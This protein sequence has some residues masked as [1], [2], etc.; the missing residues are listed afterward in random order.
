[1]ATESKKEML[2]VGDLVTP[3]GFSRVLHSLIKHWKNHYNI[4]GLGVN[5]K[6]DPH[7]LGIPVYPAQVGNSQDIYGIG[8]FLDIISQKRFDIVFILN[9]AWVISYYLKELK[10][11]NVPLPK[12]VT[13]SP[14]D[15]RYHD[16]DWYKDFDIVTKSYTYTNFGKEVMD[17]TSKN[18]NVGVIPHGTD[19]DIFYKK[20]KMASRARLFGESAEKLGKIEDLFVVLNANRNQPRKKLDITIRGFSEFAKDKPSS[21]KLYMHCGVV[22]SHI[23]IVKICERYGVAER[24][25]ISSLNRGVQ[26]VPDEKLNDI[27]NAS[28][29]GVNTCYTK[30]TKV[31]TSVG[32]KNIQDIV[33]GDIVFS[34]TGARSKVTKTFIHKN[35]KGLI[36]ITPFGIQPFTLTSNHE[37]YCDARQYTHLLR[38]YK[39]DMRKNPKLQFIS[40]ENLSE[41]SVLTFPIIKEETISLGNELAF[42]YGAYLA[43]GSASKSG[44]RFSLNSSKDNYLRDCIV[45]YMKMKFGLDAHIFNYSRNRQTIEFYSV[46]LKRTFEGLFGVGA[47][48]KNIP[49][50]F[51]KLKRR[52]KISLLNAYF[53]GDGHLSNKSG[54]L[55]FTTVSESLAWSTWYLLSTLGKV[56]PSIRRKSRGEWSVQVFGDS[57]REL[58]N[59]FSLKLKSKHK[60][61]RD[62]M[63]ADDS[64][65]YYPIK[66]MEFIKNSDTVYD[67]EVSGEHSYLTHVAG[68]NSMGEGWGLTN[69]EH[70]VTGAP[71]VVGDHSAC[72]ELFY[73]CGLLIPNVDDITFDNSLT[74][75][76]LVSSTG[77]AENLELLYTNK[78]LYN[79][80]SEKAMNKFL[81]EK[82][83]WKT[84]AN[85]WINEFESYN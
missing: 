85:T 34:H 25:I 60:Q 36:R 76:K 12:I 13:Y 46:K 61:K 54:S 27:Y 69:I 9:D 83:S 82:Y 53:L 14:V 64:Y 35:R 81:S 43:E 58:S 68:H 26:R 7:D 70:A 79:S 21:V 45:K 59:L 73:D 65:I 16:P 20:D 40:A 42:I 33:V 32:Y 3:T 67:L 19:S 78:N 56:A 39:D 71:Q 37:L 10:K 72:R 55:T 74:V 8:R 75:G 50:D 11:I 31:L 66:N 28:D 30:D 52:D 84:I 63:W 51:M 29:V 23:D 48:N 47:K 38:K 44:I 22:D 62:K 17:I 18:L 15:A 80:L 4:T 41:G 49:P 5:Y 57:A 24:L 6:G 77:L 1:M 2:V